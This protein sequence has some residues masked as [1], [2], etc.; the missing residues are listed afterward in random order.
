MIESSV[1]R[2]LWLADHRTLWS[3][4]DMLRFYGATFVAVVHNLGMARAYL[5]FADSQSANNP[6]HDGQARERF[7]TA[8]IELEAEVAKLPVSRT[9]VAQVAR[10]KSAVAAD[11]SLSD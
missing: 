6:L 8:V 7:S 1:D 3:L 2:A 4:D 5:V 9:L 11:A 10:L